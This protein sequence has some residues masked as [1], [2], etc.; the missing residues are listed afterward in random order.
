MSNVFK[1][2]QADADQRVIEIKKPTIRSYKKKHLSPELEREMQILMAQADREMDEQKRQLAEERTS[3]EQEVAQQQEA[4]KAEAERQREEA[5][6]Q[7]YDEGFQTGKKEALE[8]YSQQLEAIHQ[9]LEAAERD[10]H[11]YLEQAEEQ[12]LALALK[13]SEKIIDTTLDQE[14]GAWLNLVK[15]AVQQVREQDPIKIMVHPKWYE[16]VTSHRDELEKITHHQRV[17]IIPD[18]RFAENQCLIETPFGRIEA[19]VDS[20]LKMMRIKLFELMGAKG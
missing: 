20:Q 17:M 8:Q 4:L 2:L 16:Q 5:K 11:R 10:Y 6:A 9:V 15:Q 1:S 18:D 7:G 12:I 14:N 3:F 19:G 13:I